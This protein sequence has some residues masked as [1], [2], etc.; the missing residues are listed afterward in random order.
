[1]N[2]PIWWH[3]DKARYMAMR[4]IQRENAEFERLDIVIQGPDPSRLARNRPPPPSRRQRIVDK[5]QEMKLK[6]KGWAGKLKKKK[7]RDLC[8][9]M[10]RRRPGFC[11]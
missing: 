2:A 7:D 3:E 10:P 9:G 1:M 11:G 8:V 6:L 5:L 4:R